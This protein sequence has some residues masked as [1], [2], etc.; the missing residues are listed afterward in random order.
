MPLG[1]CPLPPD[2]GYEKTSNYYPPETLDGDYSPPGRIRPEA[3]EIAS[4]HTKGV[5]AMILSNEGMSREPSS[6]RKKLIYSTD[7][8][9][10]KNHS[11]ANKRRIREIQVRCQ[12][13]Q[14]EQSISAERLLP[15]RQDKYSH[16]TSKLGHYL[17]RSSSGA[18]VQC[19]ERG[20]RGRENEAPS[21][22]TA[23][24]Y[25]NRLLQSMSGTNVEAQPKE[26]SS[27]L[28]QHSSQS[29]TRPAKLKRNFILENIT[30]ASCHTIKQQPKVVE[31]NEETA[32]RDR[33]DKS[34]KKGTV[35]KYLLER[36]EE[37]RREEKERLA[38]LPD[39]TVPP[40]HVVM[41]TSDRLKTLETLK[42]H[43]DELLKELQSLSLTADTLRINVKR[44]QLESRLIEIEDAIKIF[45]K[46]RV[47]VKV[48]E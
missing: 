32:K 35:P 12:S 28:Q 19:G 6:T 38:S 47:F 4:R 17:P 29:E 18:T 30:S 10:P 43:Q 26:R 44:N 22:P 33:I 48:D 9:T 39:P 8:E 7:K 1:R 46:R 27:T 24:Q 23:S 31:L 37:W 11:A 25:S 45:S 36:K 41:S 20:E 16:V 3:R 5:I 42:Q 34:Y 2:P 13:R 15:P 40:G 14:R 21:A